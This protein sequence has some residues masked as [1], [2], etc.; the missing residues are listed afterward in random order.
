MRREIYE[1]VMGCTV[2]TPHEAKIVM[3]KAFITYASEEDKQVTD[4]GEES[5]ALASI[6]KPSR[7]ADKIFE[8][9]QR[10]NEYITAM[11]E[12][13]YPADID[14]DPRDAPNPGQVSTQSKVLSSL[15][16][17]VE[18]SSVRTQMPQM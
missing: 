11:M 13:H 7:W 18:R 6:R 14:R 12:G 1:K 5:N 9:V 2:K 3:Q 4:N 8:A 10:H 17:R 16:S 15:C